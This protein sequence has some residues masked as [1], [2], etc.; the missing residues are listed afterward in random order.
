MI[1]NKIPQKNKCDLIYPTISCHLGLLLCFANSAF[2]CLFSTFFSAFS[3]LSMVPTSQKGISKQRVEVYFCHFMTFLYHNTFYNMYLGLKS[4]AF[5]T[6]CHAIFNFDCPEILIQTH[7]WARYH[8]KK[9]K[10]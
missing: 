9:G 5:F 2:E 1:F 4:H 7:I 8:Y 10:K 6:H 3:P